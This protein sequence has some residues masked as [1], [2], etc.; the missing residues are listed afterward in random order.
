MIPLVHLDICHER[1]Y[2]VQLPFRRIYLSAIN[3][4]NK[5]EKICAYISQY[6]F[7]AAKTSLD[8]RLMR[9]QVCCDFEPNPC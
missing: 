3:S 7:F 1:I 4:F 5:Y 2:I 9:K 8:A 6:Q